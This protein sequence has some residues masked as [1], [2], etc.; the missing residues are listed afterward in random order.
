MLF[1]SIIPEG[2]EEVKIACTSR[3]TPGKKCDPFSKCKPVIRAVQK[4]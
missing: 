2:V 4:E 3:P 1:Q